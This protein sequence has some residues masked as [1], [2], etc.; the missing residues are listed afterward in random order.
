MKDDRNKFLIKV[1]D[2]TTQFRAKIMANRGKF[3]LTHFTDRNVK[4]SVLEQTD[5]T[6]ETLMIISHGSMQKDSTP[7]HDGS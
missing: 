6:V 4:A 2:D 5:S 1:V 3:H 7:S